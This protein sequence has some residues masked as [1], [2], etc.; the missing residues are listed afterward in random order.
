MLAKFTGRGS[1]RGFHD[2]TA[3]AKQAAEA[4]VLKVSGVK[5][6][7]NDLQVVAEKNKKAV[8]IQDEEALKAAKGGKGPGRAVRR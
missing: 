4:D 6:V 7:D 5:K 2:R 1:T 8:A 3:A